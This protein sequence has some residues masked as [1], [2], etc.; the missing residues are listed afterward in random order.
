VRDAALALQ[1]MSGPDGRDATAAEHPVRRRSRRFD[2]DPRGLRVGL[3][4][5]LVES[6]G[7]EP[8]VREA[9]LAA[10]AALAADGAQVDDA[11]LRLAPFAIPI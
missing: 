7:T 1:L 9:V 8:A 10:A 4:R 6:D 5:G 3:L 11:A 2:G